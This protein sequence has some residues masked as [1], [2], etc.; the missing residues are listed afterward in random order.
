MARLSLMMNAEIRATVADLNRELNDS[1]HIR[2]EYS[3]AL[4]KVDLSHLELINAVD[5]WH[6]SVEGHK[7]LAEA[8]F[9][10]LRPSLVFAGMGTKP[11]IRPRLQ[12]SN[13][14]VRQ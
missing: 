10:A 14:Q 8:A 7:V 11:I 5:A 3:D 2:I 6:P 1:G 12:V 13:F 4:T 9:N